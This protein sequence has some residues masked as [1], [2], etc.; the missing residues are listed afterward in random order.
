M[1][2]VDPL[3]PGD[4]EM[5]D[6]IRHLTWSTTTLGDPTTWCAG[7]RNT[8]ALCLATPAPFQIWWGRSLTLLYNDAAI[9]SIASHPSALGRTIPDLWGE[10]WSTIRSQVEQVF[11]T[12]VAIDHLGLRLTPILEADGTVS[13]LV[14]TP[15]RASARV[16]RPQDDFLA[17]VGHELRNPLSTMA[18]TLHAL[19]LRGTTPEV[20]LLSRA[21]RQLTRLVDD[22]LVSSRLARGMIELQPNVIELSQVIAR[23]V[24]LV[25]PWFEDKQNKLAVTVPSEGLRIDADRARLARAI[26]NVL[27][28]ASQYGAIGST[29]RIDANLADGQIVLRIADDGAGIAHDRLSSVFTAFQQE[30]RSGGLGLGLAIARRVVAL[31]HGSI[32]VY[33]EGLG[34]GTE[35]RIQLPASG[36]RPQVEPAMDKVRK[37]LLVVEDT[38]DAARALKLALEQLGYEV[39]LAHDAPI[40][41]NLAKT[42]RPDVVLLDLGL[43]VMDGWELAQRLRGAS[44]ELPIV[45][46]TARDQDAD[47][48]RSAELGFAE[49]LVK[50]I[51]LVELERIVQ[52]VSIRPSSD[53]AQ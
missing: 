32:A 20:E 16:T 4:S 45:A 10:R 24:E 52:S 47:K 5:V 36:A 44:G 22:L 12:G 48:Q 18:T 35:C 2:T 15:D 23:A 29:I 38:D 17:M 26:S 42:F 27:M 50:P 1:S 14:C 41:L 30:R 6:R 39:A 37:R 28:N 3:P 49:H 40:A 53:D 11:E 51:D 25:A 7:L 34:K 9:P 19:Q 8:L 13:G 31:H 33:S 46:V 21:Q 43:P